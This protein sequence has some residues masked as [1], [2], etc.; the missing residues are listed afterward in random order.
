MMSCA[1]IIAAIC[2]AFFCQLPSAQDYPAKA[3]RIIVPVGPAG[4]A[5]I[6]TRALGQRLAAV[7]GQ[8]VVVDN[9]AGGGSNIGFEAAARAPADGYTLLL[10]NPAFTVNVSLYKKLGYDALRDF[11]PVTLT[12]TTANVLVVHPTVPARSLKELIAFAKAR[13]GQ[14]SYASSGNGSTPHLSGELLKTTVGIDIKHIPYKSAAPAVIDLLGGHVDAAFVALASVVPQIKVQKLR[15]LGV[16]TAKRSALMPDLPTFME[17]G[18][19]GYDVSGWYCIMVPTGTPR[20][21]IDRLHTDITRSLAQPD[22]AQMLTAAGIEPAASAS[23]EEL[24]SFL[25]AEISKWAKVVR[26]SGA[27]VQ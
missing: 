25:R 12:A 20:P 17:A 4:A 11:S 3:V 24:A 14:L 5:D 16:T 15:A 26:A 21:I 27:T 22:L 13:P 19:A 23:P 6:L 10:A 9:R 1:R 8:P 18:L 7:W 2:T